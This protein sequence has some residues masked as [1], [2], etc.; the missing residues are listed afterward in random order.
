MEFW[1]AHA[2]VMMG[3]QTAAT[4]IIKVGGPGPRPGGGGGNRKV[5]PPR[6]DGAD[7]RVGWST[8]HDQAGGLT[9]APCCPVV[10]ARCSTAS[11][12]R[13]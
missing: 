7:A 6:H 5:Y 9:N 13:T 1:R 4:K 10:V 3:D 2:A 11:G 8:E 12:W